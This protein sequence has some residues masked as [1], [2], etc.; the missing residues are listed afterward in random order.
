[1]SSGEQ[2]AT[3]G[4]K[5]C[6]APSVVSQSGKCGMR[7]REG[8]RNGYCC[9]LFAIAVGL[10]GVPQLDAKD[11]AP[12]GAANMQ[13]FKGFAHMFPPQY[14]HMLH[15]RQTE[16][17]E[18]NARLTE[19]QNTLDE[20]V[21]SGGLH[22]LLA[23]TGQHVRGDEDMHELTSMVSKL[24]RPQSPEERSESKVG[25]H[26]LNARFCRG[27]SASDVTTLLTNTQAPHEPYSELYDDMAAILHLNG[28]VIVDRCFGSLVASE[29][30]SG[31]GLLMQDVAP[32]ASAAGGATHPF[33]SDVGRLS[34]APV[35]LHEH[36][37]KYLHDARHTWEAEFKAHEHPHVHAIS[38]HV[39][40]MDVLREELNRRLPA[41]LRT[42]NVTAT[43]VREFGSSIV[44]TGAAQRQLGQQPGRSSTP[45]VMTLYF[46]EE[47]PGSKLVLRVPL[48]NTEGTAHAMLQVP[49]ECIEDDGTLLVSTEIAADRLVVLLPER[50]GLGF[51][52]SATAVGLTNW[53]F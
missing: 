38:D 33:G 16:L 9:L 28:V 3:A 15:D 17:G 21:L 27:Y 45:Q 42:R 12:P 43:L 19:L 22:D 50:V 34:G 25:L 48:R 52:G 29:V 40:D 37:L 26:A 8:A 47:V 24:F 2:A 31:S 11:K 41:D 18:R 14:E 7:P 36:I 20:T 5:S 10:L 46:P 13:F 4:A 1:M 51:N 35:A 23:Q 39:L 30:H 6:A 53:Y 44:P 49:S 32:S